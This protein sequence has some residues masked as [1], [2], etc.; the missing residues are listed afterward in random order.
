MPVVKRKQSGSPRVLHIIDSLH[1]G[2]V[3]HWLLRLWKHA[4]EAGRPFDW[5]FY[6]TLPQPGEIEQQ[7]LADGA[8]VVHSPVVLKEKTAFLRALRSHVRD[9]NYEIVHSHHDLLSAFYWGGIAGLGCRRITHVHNTDELIPT[10]SRWKRLV[11]PEIMRVGCLHASH[12]MIATSFHALDQFLAGRARDPAR[13]MV[14]YCSLDVMNYLQLRAQRRAVR[15]EL[16]LPLEADLLVFVGRLIDLKNPEF[17]L[18]VLKYLL[19]ARPGAIAVFA[20]DGPDAGNLRDRTATLGLADHVRILGWRED[21]P[22][23]MRA[24][25]LFI[26]PRRPRP[27]EGFGLVV[28][29]AQ[30]AGLRILISDGISEEAVLKGSVCRQLP[31]AAGAGAWAKAAAELLEVPKLDDETVRQMFTRSSFDLDRAVDHL[32]TIYDGVL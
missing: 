14:H 16:G 15:H 23:L 24:A 22:R 5:T 13:H 8:R 29:E 26:N 9:G 19:A 31:L 28:L 25:D 10:S 21:I 3:E 1:R 7:A 32:H 11:L 17:V 12:R 4:L 20:G 6:C 27:R 18:D 30:A 2:S